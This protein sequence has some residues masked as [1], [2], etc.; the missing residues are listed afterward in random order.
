[1]IVPLRARGHTLGA[2]T[3]VAAESGG[4]STRTTSRSPPSWRAERRFR[5]TTRACTATSR[6]GAGSSSSSPARAP[7]S[8]QSLDLDVTL[9]RVADLTVPYLADGCMVDL[10]DE[11]EVIRASRIAVVGSRRSSRCSIACACTI[12]DLDSAHPIAIAMRTGRLQRGRRHR[13]TSF[14]GTWSTDEQYLD[15]IREWPARSAVVAPMRARGKTLG[16]I[17][18]ASLHA[19]APSSDAT[20]ASIEELARQRR[21]RSR[22][23]A[24]VYG[25]TQLHR[26]AAPAEPAAASP[27]GD[28]RRRDRS[29][30][31]A[32]RRGQ[33]RRRRL[34]RHLRDRHRRLGDHDRATCAGRAPTPR[35]SPRWRATRCARP[36][37]RAA[38]TPDDAAALLND[39]ML[40]EAPDGVPVLHGRVRQLPRSA[41]DSTELAIASGGHP[42]PIVLH[43]GRHR[44]ERSASRARCSAWC[45]TRI[46]PGRA[47]ARAVAATR[48]SS[49]PTASPRRARPAAGCSGWRV[50]CRPCGM[51]RV[52][53]RRGRG[54]DRA[55][56]LD[57]RERRAAR[58][59]SRSWS[60]R[61]SGAGRDVARAR[62]RARR[63]PSTAP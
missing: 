17:A 40:T 32:R 60:C 2:V 43:A 63:V 33:R 9:Q 16:T 35:R 11:T 37:I 55:A 3:F 10:L 50:C 51:R 7:S 49:T 4:C 30:V 42:L 46:A 19:T 56:L 26:G 8:T 52:R 21:V 23:R 25:E 34:L 62:V 58:T 22:Q 29:P 27:A 31:P 45:P 48:S 36:A 14:A 41:P 24:P 12:I 15:D 53:R 57:R 44:R 61:S 59:T 18:L 39:A 13:R 20:F 47:R 28:P 6:H 1:M 5:S 38:K 54:A